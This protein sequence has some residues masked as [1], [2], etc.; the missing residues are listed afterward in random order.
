MRL[1]RLLLLALIVLAGGIY[2]SLIARPAAAAPARLGVVS[3]RLAPG[4][5][6]PVAAPVTLTV[7]FDQ[8]VL[9]ASW[10]WLGADGRPVPWA[11]SPLPAQDLRP[12]QNTWVGLSPE[13]SGTQMPA[14]PARTLNTS[15]SPPPFVHG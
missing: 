8:N 6:W 2:L 11:G 9:L 10:Q 3:A 4:S 7:Q 13:K 14:S 5:S 15:H 12:Q 1:N